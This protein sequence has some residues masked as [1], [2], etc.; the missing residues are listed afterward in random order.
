MQIDN[1]H[2]NK[3]PLE[4]GELVGGPYDGDLRITLGWWLISWDF[5]VYRRSCRMSAFGLDVYC[6]DYAGYLFDDPDLER[7]LRAQFE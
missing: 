6:Y 5:H 4:H 1:E 3:D 7:Q 2:S